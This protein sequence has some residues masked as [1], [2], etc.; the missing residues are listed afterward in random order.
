[1]SNHAGLSDK[2]L[3]KNVR[4]PLNA[5]GTVTNSAVIDM[6]GWDGARFVINIGVLGTNGTVDAKVL[7]DDNSGLNSLTAITNAQLTQ[8]VNAN[9]VQIIDVFR[10][11]ERYLAL[12]T[13][14]HTNGAVI[15]A[16]VDLYRGNG[17]VL[18]PTQS[19][20]QYV[21]VAES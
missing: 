3:T 13:A 17:R 4:S 8:V 5:S 7:R 12:Q 19:A 14:G 16:T 6:Q 2:V 20:E 21:R 18:P 10:P 11:S 15:S 1:M 9:T